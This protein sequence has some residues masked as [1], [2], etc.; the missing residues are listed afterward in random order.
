MKQL[1]QTNLYAVKVPKDATHIKINSKTFCLSYYHNKNVDSFYSA[2]CSEHNLYNGCKIIGTV[3]KD[4]IDFDCGRYVEDSKWYAKMWH[5]Y[6]PHDGLRPLL[7]HECSTKEQSFYSLLEVNEFYFEN[8]ITQPIWDSALSG[9]AS[10]EY[11]FQD[12][13]KQWLSH[14]DKVV[15]KL[16]IIVKI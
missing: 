13:M 8:P 2:F 7:S 1:N 4:T 11:M 6:N 3:T 5:N 9:N 15:E 10:I 16:L 14:Q 12:K